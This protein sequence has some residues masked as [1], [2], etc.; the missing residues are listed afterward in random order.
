M[1]I[2]SSQHGFTKG[3]SSLT[4]LTVFYDE[5]NCLVN[6]ENAA[7]AVYLDFSKAFDVVSCNVLTDKLTKYR[8][9]KWKIRW[10]EN[11]LNWAQRIV[12]SGTKSSWREV[13]NDVPQRLIVGLILFSIFT[14][15]LG[16]RAES[17]LSK[18][19]IGTKL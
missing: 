12:I 11:W 3:K 16:A 17:I 7:D 4:N 9:D 5:M 15:E 19:V 14:N 10:I 2:G 1:V 6:E 18:F 8:L 13:T